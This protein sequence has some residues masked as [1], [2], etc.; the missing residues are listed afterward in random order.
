MRIL[1][2]SEKIYAGRKFMSLVQDITQKFG[3]RTLRA[4]L[5]ANLHE[6]INN[7]I[8]EAEQ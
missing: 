5:D 2:E 1:S 7:G 6:T 4:S 8:K 3:T